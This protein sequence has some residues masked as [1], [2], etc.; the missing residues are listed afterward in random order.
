MA[1]SSPHAVFLDS[2]RT[3]ADIIKNHYFQMVYIKY[4]LYE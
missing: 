2:C 4:L 1:N 3:F